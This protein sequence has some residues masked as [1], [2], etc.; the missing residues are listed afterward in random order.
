M[1][2]RQVAPALQV[3]REARDAIRVRWPALRGRMVRDSG[4]AAEST[5]FV[6]LHAYRS[7]LARVER[8]GVVVRDPDEGLVD[9]L[10]MRDGQPVWLCWRLGDGDRIAWWHPLDRGA[11]DRQAL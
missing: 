11:A 1:A 6:A 9:F 2:L 8:L 4:G 3:V 10:G 7:A 5:L